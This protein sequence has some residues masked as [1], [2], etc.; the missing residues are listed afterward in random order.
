VHTL[1]IRNQAAHSG[2]PLAL[3]F[4]TSTHS[5]TA[6]PEQENNQGAPDKSHVPQADIPATGLHH[7]NQRRDKEKVTDHMRDEYTKIDIKLKHNSM[8]INYIQGESCSVPGL[9]RSGARIQWL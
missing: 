3:A 9:V 6:D 2:P 4:P 8:N 1:R 7:S 5:T